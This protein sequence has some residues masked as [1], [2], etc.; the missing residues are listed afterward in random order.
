MSK[1]DPE[2]Y[3]EA[4]RRMNVKPEETVIVED[5]AHG[6]EAA[7]RSGG[8]V[9]H[10]KGFGEVDYERIKGFISDLENGATHAR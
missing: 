3:L 4:F 9:C 8:H 5:N 10:V 7:K 2:M 6:V 1:P